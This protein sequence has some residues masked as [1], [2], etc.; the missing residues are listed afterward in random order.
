MYAQASL[1]RP[2]RSRAVRKCASCARRLTLG[3]FRFWWCIWSSV[4][5]HIP[6]SVVSAVSLWFQS[7]ERLQYSFSNIARHVWRFSLFAIR[8]SSPVQDSWAVPALDS[9]VES[10]LDSEVRPEPNLGVGVERYAGPWR[11]RAMKSSRSKGND[12]SDWPPSTLASSKFIS[13]NAFATQWIFCSK[14]VRVACVS[15]LNIL[16][17]L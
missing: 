5:I 2:S 14:Q 13:S 1:F 10:V 15:G 16:C 9:G 6:L 11:Q 17:S 12:L 4:T 7:M 8:S 3:N